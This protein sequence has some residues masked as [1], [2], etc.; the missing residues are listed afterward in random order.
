MLAKAVAKQKSFK[1]QFS[2]FPYIW[3]Q[4]VSRINCGNVSQYSKAQDQSEGLP[5][6]MAPRGFSSPDLYGMFDCNL[7]A[8]SPTHSE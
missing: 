2:A 4:D 1:S 6:F 7:A 8:K 5:S 3:V